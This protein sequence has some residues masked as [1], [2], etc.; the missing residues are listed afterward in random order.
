MP[1]S[2]VSSQQLSGDDMSN[3]NSHW[4]KIAEDRADWVVDAVA[5]ATQNRAFLR[6]DPECDE[7]ACDAI[8]LNAEKAIL[9]SLGRSGASELLGAL[10]VALGALKTA[11][12][13]LTE[14]H[15]AVLKGAW[16][17]SAIEAAE[18]AIAKAESRA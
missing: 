14:D 18:A 17:G 10:K 1:L 6:G 12:R 9:V 7:V 4:N 16:G 15:K 13:Q 5:T 11:S 3:A 2:L 8:K